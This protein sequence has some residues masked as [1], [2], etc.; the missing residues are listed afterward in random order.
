MNKLFLQMVI[1][2]SGMGLVVVAHA[3][4]YFPQGIINAGI[5]RQP[6]FRIQH[7][8]SS[9]VLSPDKRVSQRTMLRFNGLPLKGIPSCYQCHGDYA[10]GIPPWLPQLSRGETKDT[11]LILHWRSTL[12]INDIHHDLLAVG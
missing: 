12:K 3:N 5:K 11:R 6:I 4:F 9:H 2:V 8:I 7:Q 10:L 1:A